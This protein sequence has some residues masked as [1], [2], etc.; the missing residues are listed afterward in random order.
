MRMWL[1]MALAA[2]A[3][4]AQE[5]YQVPDG[6]ET[7]WFSP[8]N[9]Q[10]EKGAAGQV[11]AGRKGRPRIPVK[12]GEQVVLAEVKASSGTVRRIWM[13]I[14]NRSPQMLRSLRLDFYW[15]GASKPAISAPFGDFFGTGIGR[16]AP[17]QSVFFA[18]PEGKSFNCFIPMPFRKGMKIVLTNE[19]ETSLGSLYYD[20]DVTLGDRHPA[21]AGYLHAWFNHQNPTEYQRDFEILARVA[22][23]GRFLG[24]NIGVICDQ[25]RYLKTWWGEGEVKVYIDG[26]RELPTLSGTGTEDYIGTGWGQGAFSNLYTGCPV[27]DRDNMR[28][29]FY[30]YHVPDPVYF[31]KDVRVTIQQIGAANPEALKA[32]RAAGTELYRAGPGLV[33]HETG[34]WERQDDW[35][36]TAYFYL[37]RPRNDLPPLE[38]LA[39]RLA[40]L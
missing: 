7:R 22:G 31:R 9:P 36:S 2:A 23:R 8:E 24:C 19:G 14:N 27:A 1:L 20:I 11:N 35:S 12:A 4:G 34:L 6:L 38:P 5:L 40:G 21:G 33:K 3:A 37:D 17:F 30:R 26:D 13:T 15:D 39:K 16:M 25:K 10:G 28:Y 32:M 18:S 29:A